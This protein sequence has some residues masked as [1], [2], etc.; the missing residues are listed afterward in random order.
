MKKYAFVGN[1]KMNMTRPETRALASEIKALFS[2]Y[3]RALVAIAPPFT[4]LVEAMEVIKGTNIKLCA[5]N[6]HWNRSGA[7]TGEVSPVMLKEIGVEYV[8]LGH[9]E[10]RQF[11]GE[12]DAGV[13]KRAKGAIEEGLVPIV[14]VGET[15]TER[16]QNKTIEVVKNQVLGC[17]KDLNISD[18][19][20]LM[21][22]YEP[23]W[24][25][26]TGLVARPEEVA[27]VHEFIRRLLI[28]LFG[29]RGKEIRILYGG[30]VKAENI[31]SL[32]NLDN[33][34]GA[35]VGGASLVAKEFFSIASSIIN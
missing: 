9:S 16:E 32:I 22:A 19:D 5:Q 27:E 31:R 15:K 1:W 3:D 10:R 12:S 25:I 20:A 18:S 28:E 11:F 13:N 24:A 26:G 6:C 35:L 17:L 14:C 7:F 8:I 21:I 30:S 34:N 23:V 33:V 29:D 4:S 2:N